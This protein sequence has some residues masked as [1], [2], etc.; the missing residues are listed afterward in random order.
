MSLNSHILV[1]KSLKLMIQCLDIWIEHLL[2]VGVLGAFNIH[3][4]WIDSYFG[5]LASKKY[6]DFFKKIIQKN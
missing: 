3:I 2:F 5:R 1:L 4:W 6:S